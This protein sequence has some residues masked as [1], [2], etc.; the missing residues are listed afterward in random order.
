MPAP[1]MHADQL[2]GLD[3]DALTALIG[4]ADFTR[5]D[6][7]AELWQYRASDCILDLFLYATPPQAVPRVAHVETRDRSDGGAGSAACV[8]TLLDARRMSPKGRTS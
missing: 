8:T 3:R 1:P 4:P 5:S 7:P 2:L 6:G